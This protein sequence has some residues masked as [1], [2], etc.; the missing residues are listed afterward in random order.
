MWYFHVY[1]GAQYFSKDKNLELQL[2]LMELINS[3]LLF[4]LFILSG[5]FTLKKIII[6][7]PVQA[8]LVNCVLQILPS[9]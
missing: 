2:K 6:C 4:R 5:F 3:C 9:N 7:N 1:K 8:D